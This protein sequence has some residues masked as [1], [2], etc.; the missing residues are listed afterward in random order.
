MSKDFESKVK[1][2]E[3]ELLALK[4]ASEYASLQSA[5][6]TYSQQVRTGVYRINY[7][8]PKNIKILSILYG[9]GP[10]A[11]NVQ[12]M[13]RTPNNN[14]QLVDVNTLVYNEST[15]SYITVNATMSII[16]NVP[17]TSITRIS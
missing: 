4:T 12:V 7:N 6:I 17:V 5:S 14:Y 16:S 2:I 13:G 1:W 11:I 9:G 3:D 10:Y 8:N 15:G